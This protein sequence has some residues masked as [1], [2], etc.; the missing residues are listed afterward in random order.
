[1]LIQAVLSRWSSLDD[2]NM[3]TLE[4][5]FDAERFA[6]AMTR[7]PYIGLWSQSSKDEY[8]RESLDFL[9]PPGDFDECRLIDV[10]WS[11]DRNEAVVYCYLRDEDAAGLAMRCWVA[12]AGC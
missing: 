4:P 5:H 7:S 1:M 10:R 11:A 6:A 8:R 9:E 12:R 2:E 3:R